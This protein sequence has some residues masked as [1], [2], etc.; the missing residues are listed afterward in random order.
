MAHPDGSC[1][2]EQLFHHL[3]RLSPQRTTFK[4]AEEEGTDMRSM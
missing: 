4:Q 1:V 3:L 2:S